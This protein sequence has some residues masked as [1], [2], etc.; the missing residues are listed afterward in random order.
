[1]LKRILLIFLMLLISSV[2]LLAQGVDDE[3]NS[4]D[5]NSNDRANACYDET[6]NCT[7][8]W[9]WICG[10]HF[11]RWQA[12]SSYEMPLTCQVLLPGPAPV[13]NPAEEGSRPVCYDN[14]FSD[15]RLTGAINTSP[16]G[17]FYSSFDGTCATPIRVE[18]TLVSAVDVASA[19][20]ICATII[21]GRG[22]PITGAAVLAGGD[23][24]ANYWFCSYVVI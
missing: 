16:N 7:S 24:P 20:A 8:E 6:A 13:E 18:G 14:N 17:F 10:W 11:I 3:G 21:G 5:P 15:F 9:D 23:F 19:N 4:N 1:M 22:L 2:S 12:D